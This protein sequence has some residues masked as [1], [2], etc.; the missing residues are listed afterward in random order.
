[1]LNQ[2][3]MENDIISMH[4]EMKDYTGDDQQA[5][6]IFAKRWAEIWV[7]HIK[8]LEIVYSGGLVAPNGAVGGT[9]NH[10]VR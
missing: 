1:M 9:I 2:E 5:L 10:T 8:T 6:K 4:T 3:Q 7:K